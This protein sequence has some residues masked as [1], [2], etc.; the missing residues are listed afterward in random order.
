MKQRLARSMR[1]GQQRREPPAA[2]AHHS[3]F[4]PRV[5]DIGKQH[6]V[7]SSKTCGRR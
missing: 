3:E 6:R 1:L 2:S 5:S 4:D 7:D